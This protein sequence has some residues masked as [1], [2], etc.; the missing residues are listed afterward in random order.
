MYLSLDL[1]LSYAAAWNMPP[2]LPTAPNNGL[3]TVNGLAVTT[4]L[5]DLLLS[6]QLG[7]I[8]CFTWQQQCR[9]R[10]TFFYQLQFL[11]KQLFSHYRHLQR[12]NEIAIVS[13]CKDLRKALLDPFVSNWIHLFEAWLIHQSLGL[14]K[15]K[16]ITVFDKGAFWCLKHA[17]Q[18]AAFEQRLGSLHL[19]EILVSPLPCG[20]L[21]LLPLL[22][23][24]CAFNINS[25]LYDC[26]VI[27]GIFDFHC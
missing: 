11:L 1:S 21:L 2:C 23:L 26:F 12:K 6:M 14:C 17:P 13:N 15:I 4:S 25:G 24:A 20:R 9:F 18:L 10:W 5:W 27:F 8:V 3:A 19:G 16:I 22:L 7:I